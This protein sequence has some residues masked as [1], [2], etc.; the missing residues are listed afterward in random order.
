[1]KNR[2]RPPI[3][4]IED[5]SVY[6]IKYIEE[7]GDYSLWS[8]NLKKNPNGPIKVEFFYKT[9]PT[10]FEEDQEKLPLTKRKF[11]NEETNKVLSYQRAKIL[12]LI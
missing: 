5:N 11:Y 4:P 9:T 10:T 6:M 8:Y 7:N 2:G 1:L 12:N 3:K